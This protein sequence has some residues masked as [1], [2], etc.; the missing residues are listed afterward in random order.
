[1]DVD[2]CTQLL[3]FFKIRSGIFLLPGARTLSMSQIGKL[4][5]RDEGVQDTKGS[6]T[7]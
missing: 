2:N 6:R 5:G 3:G 4:E 7:V 1:M